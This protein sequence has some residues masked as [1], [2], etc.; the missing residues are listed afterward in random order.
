MQ[1]A[2]TT[3]GQAHHP[4]HHPAADVTSTDVVEELRSRGYELYTVH[5]V[6]HIP[7]IPPPHEPPLLTKPRAIAIAV[8]VSIPAYRVVHTTTHPYSCPSPTSPDCKL[9]LGVWNAVISYG[10]TLANG[11]LSGRYALPAW[12]GDYRLSDVADLYDD[13]S[14]MDDVGELYFGDMGT[15]GGFMD[16]ITDNPEIL[17]ILGGLFQA[18]GAALTARRVAEL[19]RANVPR[20]YL[21]R[22]DLPALLQALQGVA[23]P[24]Q[25]DALARGAQQ[26]TMPVWAI[27]AMI[28]GG[29]LVLM[30]MMKK[31]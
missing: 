24:S 22:A 26:A 9:A 13:M 25:L 12:A 19:L 14:D 30:L 29:F 6:P 2:L 20:D 1:T 21:T 27:P 31:S 17:T 7:H 15:L 3:W 18:A 16:W 11:Y 5:H 8:D 10:V 28:G 4:A 23:D